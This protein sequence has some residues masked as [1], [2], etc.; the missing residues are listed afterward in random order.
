MTPVIRIDDQVMDELK[1][2]AVDL[3][4][5]FEPPNT[6]LRKVLGLDWGEAH[7]DKAVDN[8]VEF[9][10]RE[11]DRRYGRFYLRGLKGDRRVLPGFKQDFEL[12]TD[13][14]TFTAHIYSAPR[15]TPEGDPNAGKRIRGRLRP[16][17]DKHPELKPRDKLRVSVLEPMKKYRLEIVK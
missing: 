16:W 15:G 1:K 10:F 3:G 4:L 14:G 2:R 17:F 12:V 7:V 8:A 9:E 6:T 5:V 11:N 13:V